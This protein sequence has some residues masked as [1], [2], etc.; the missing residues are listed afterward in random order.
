MFFFV[1]THFIHVCVCNDGNNNNS[2]DYACLLLQ[3]R[4]LMYTKEKAMLNGVPHAG[5][6][7]MLHV[8]S[9]V[10]TRN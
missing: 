3:L 9:N 7:N 8:C 4:S 1:Y 5:E 10:D 2:D 6:N